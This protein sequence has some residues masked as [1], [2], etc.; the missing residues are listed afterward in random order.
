MADDGFDVSFAITIT[1]ERAGT[2]VVQLY[3]SDRFASVSRPVV[4]LIGFRRVTLEPGQQTRVVFHVE[5]SQLAFLDTDMRWRVEA[6]ELD[7]LVGA[8]SADIRLKGSIC[9]DSDALIDGRNR[10][11][12][13]S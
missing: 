8:S 4:E 9:I 13:A 12:Y 3:S 1:G 10:S 7:I 6:G 11:F 5:T 2:E